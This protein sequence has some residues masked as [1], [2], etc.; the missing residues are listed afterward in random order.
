[1][2]DVEVNVEKSIYQGVM[3]GILKRK[4]SITKTET[5]GDLFCLK[6]DVALREMF[7]YAM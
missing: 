5:K 3:S 2:M 7:G 6:V 4:G 1:M